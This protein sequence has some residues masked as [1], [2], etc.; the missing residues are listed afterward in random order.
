MPYPAPANLLPL[1]EDPDAPPD[2]F[3]R[4]GVY[5]MA[6]GSVQL[7]EGVNHAARTDDLIMAVNGF[8][9]M[10]SDGRPRHLTTSLA[11]TCSA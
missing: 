8:G 10:R 5:N 3:R 7:A 1:L 2:L 6:G 4:W 9:S 11:L